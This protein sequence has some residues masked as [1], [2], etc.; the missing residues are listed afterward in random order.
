M[1]KRYI[2]DTCL[3]LINIHIKFREKTNPSTYPLTLHLKS[4]TLHDGIIFLHAGFQFLLA[5]QKP[6]G[7]HM[8]GYLIGLI[9]I[10][11]PVRCLRGWQKA[12]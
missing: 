12:A 10:H 6:A 9:Y 7:W 8:L 4:P 11:W 5:V 3:L 1:R 2:T